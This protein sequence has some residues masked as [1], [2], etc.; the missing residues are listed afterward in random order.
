MFFYN[1]CHRASNHFQWQHSAVSASKEYYYIVEEIERTYYVKIFS[2]SKIV[3]VD[4][5]KYR[6]RDRF[7]ITW[8][9]NRDILWI[10]SSDIGTFCLFI[11][12]GEWVRKYYLDCLGKGFD[13]PK[14][15]LE[16]Y[17]NSHPVGSDGEL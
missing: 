2:N 11:E 13:L 3:Y 10:Y 8:D 12:D 4:S 17:P 7:H 1:C 14:I 16:M 5:E 6:M 15:F 9:E